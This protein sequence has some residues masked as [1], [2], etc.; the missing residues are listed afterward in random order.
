MEPAAATDRSARA[1][2]IDAAQSA[3]IYD[4]LV[5][6]G[7]PAGSALAALLARAG[8]RVALCERDNFPRDKLCGEF[9]SGESRRLLAELGCLGEL[10]ALRPAAIRAFHFSAPSGAICRAALPSPALGI[11]RRALDDVLLRHAARSGA[12]VLQGV[13]ARGV[14]ALAPTGS[15]PLEYRVDL[16]SQVRAAAT[17]RL[18]AGLVVAA[19]GR[20]ARLD[21]ELGR[22]FLRRTHPHVG[23]K[24]HH[25]PRS[26][27]AGKRLASELDGAIEIHAF[28]GGYC[29]ISFVESGVVNVCML[30]G[31]PFLASLASS[32]WADV[33]EAL[34]RANL[35]LA[36]RL[37]AL[38]PSEDSVHAVAGI[39]FS[40]KER[41][42]EGILF[43]GD[44][45]G[46]IA[47][48]CGDGQ[49]MALRS[50]QLLAELI[51]AAPIQLRDADSRALA[52]RWE[53]CWRREFGLR[54]R[55]GRL[56]QPLLVGGWTTDAALRFAAL[57]PAIP[58]W[59]ARATR[60]A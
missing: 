49:A 20:R 8:R 19:H 36:E 60:G 48:F 32:R 3:E 50:A 42:S 59:I 27:A 44:A 51:L 56:L 5:I 30:V 57:T 25:R 7:G 23:L 47:P 17:D 33:R 43:V 28:R 45:A 40:F 41:S 31:E 4:A 37:D 2:T 12:A 21:A 34:C 29:G 14:E 11:S 6:G 35:R 52:R 54:M 9:L 39:P 10:E 15:R 22:S 58:S 53:K 18:T 16:R 13:Q 24:R 1:A 26:G 55:V 46:M 38:E